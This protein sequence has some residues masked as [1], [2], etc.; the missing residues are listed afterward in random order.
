VERIIVDSTVLEKAVDCTTDSRLLDA[1][2]RKLVLTA[3]QYRRL[4][5]V[6]KR[7][8]TIL[9]RI[10][11]EQARRQ[12]AL[13]DGMNAICPLVARAGDDLDTGRHGCPGSP[14]RNSLS[15]LSGGDPP[16]RPGQKPERQGALISQTPSG[17]GA[18]DRASEG[19]QRTL[20]N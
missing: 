11:R 19:R 9:G 5:R 7:Q 10:L 4:R 15:G 3:K 8:R 14:N 17:G 16:P 12:P 6:L 1:A 13:C 20:P 18:C 2:R